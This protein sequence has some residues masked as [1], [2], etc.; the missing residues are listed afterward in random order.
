LGRLEGGWAVAEGERES[1]RRG[2][3]KCILGGGFIRNET[4]LEVAGRAVV[5]CMFC[6]LTMSC[7]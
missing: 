4:V 6:L 3:G 2:N 7:M 1:R 5:I